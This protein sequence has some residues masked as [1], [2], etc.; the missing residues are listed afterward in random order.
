MNKARKKSFLK[1]LELAVNRETEAFNY[2]YKASKKAPYPETESLLIQ[3]A[4]EE[5][6]HRTFLIEELQRIEKNLILETNDNFD[7]ERDVRFPIP[8]D[9]S[10][11]RLNSSQGID[12]AA[13]SL[14]TEFI[15]GDY[16]ETIKLKRE[17]EISSLAIFLCDVMGH[18]LEAT[19]IKA[20]AKKAIGQLRETWVKG[21]GLVDLSKPEQIITYLNQEL[22][23]ECKSCHRYVSAFYGVLDANKKTLTYTSAG[24]DPPILIKTNNEYYHLN[25]TELLLG[26]EKDLSYAE[27]TI[28][29]NIGDVLVLFSDGI[30]E[31]FNSREEQFERERLCKVVQKAQEA[32]ASE[33]ILQIIYALRDFLDGEPLTDEF[34]LAV[35]K[36]NE[37]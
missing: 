30:T 20:L 10:F 18:S 11:K 29:L 34:T 21:Q 15:G 33:I 8:T 4:E 22:I 24:H 37:L 1:A 16:L 28:P 14:P 32:S 3:L 36:I 2:Y 25:N 31:A 26:I 19:Q 17:G 35:M 9:I 7:L 23:D 6:K 27:V 5:R 12:L 13:I